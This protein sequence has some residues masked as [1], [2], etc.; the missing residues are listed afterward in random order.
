MKAK[1]DTLILIILVVSI[2]TFVGCTQKPQEIDPILSVVEYDTRTDTGR[3]VGYQNDKHIRI[4]I[5]GVPETI[6]EKIFL[7]DDLIRTKIKDID[8]RKD[9]VVKFEY[10]VNE[11]GENVIVEI[12]I[13]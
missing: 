13:L 11:D 10:Y 9:D 8:L 4:M 2:L 3:F 5:S 7:V 6:A 1:F 12:T